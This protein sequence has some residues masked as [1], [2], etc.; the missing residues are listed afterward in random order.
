MFVLDARPSRGGQAEQFP[1]QQAQDTQRS[2]PAIGSAPSCGPN[3]SRS[4][5]P[6]TGDGDKGLAAA[7]ILCSLVALGHP[8]RRYADVGAGKLPGGAGECGGPF[9][10]VR[11]WGLLAAGLGE[12]FKGRVRVDRHAVYEQRSRGIA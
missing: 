2:T 9:F 5:T 1:P 4:Y 10:T 6:L 3:M 11:K 12:V 8:V 7:K